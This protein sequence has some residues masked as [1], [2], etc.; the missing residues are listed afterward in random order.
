ML[1]PQ[2]PY[3]RG[4]S[5]PCRPSVNTQADAGPADQREAGG[6]AEAKAERPPTRSCQD[7]EGALIAERQFYVQHNYNSLN[8]V[9]GAVPV[10][11]GIVLFYRNRTFTDQ[12]AGFGSGMKKGIGRGQMQNT[13]VKLFKEA[14]RQLEQGR[15]D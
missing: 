14:Q 2:A 1:R 8:L 9:V 11:G 4:R 3:A 10:E 13:I 15:L 5:C 7:S 12:V 6:R